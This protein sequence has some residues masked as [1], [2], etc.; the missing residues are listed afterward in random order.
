[1]LCLEVNRVVNV[2]EN[3]IANTIV[4]ETTI[5]TLNFLDTASIA[6]NYYYY[7]YYKN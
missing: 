6:H 4:R 2:T 1:M 5:Q 7:Y 3:T